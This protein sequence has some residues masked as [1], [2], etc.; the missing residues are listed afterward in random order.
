MNC[1]ALRIYF[2]EHTGE[3]HGTIQTGVECT[4]T[5]FIIVFYLDASQ[6]VVP[7]LTPCFLRLLE[8]FLADFLQVQFCLFGA[9][10][11][12]SDL[13]M[14]LFAFLRGE[15]DSCSHMIGLQLQMF[16]YRMIVCPDFIERER[17]VELYHEIVLKVPWNA[18][19]VACRI[20]HDFVFFGDHLHIRT[21]IKSIYHDIRIFRFG[22][23]E[24]EISTTFCRS[25][26]RCQIIF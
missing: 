12:G 6:H 18:A 8:G 25:N 16:F 3:K 23:S 14:H 19:A 15:T 13:G 5:V 4:H 7:S 10:E 11:R 21:A 9:D 1:F 24:P 22:K 20:S 26:F 17:F 2:I